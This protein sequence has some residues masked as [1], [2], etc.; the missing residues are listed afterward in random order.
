MIQEP[1]NERTIPTTAPEESAAAPGERW[2]ALRARLALIR[3]NRAIA[4][5]L[6]L[7]LFFLGLSLIAN[8]SGLLRADVQMTQRIQRLEAGGG[9]LVSVARLISDL[10][11]A[12]PL[13]LVSLPAV[14]WLLRTRHWKAAAL[15][16]LA[17]T[18]GH[19][20]NYLI[21]MLINR[22]R[23]TAEAVS[24]FMPGIGSSFPSG[25]A[26]TAVM[27]FGFLAVMAS[28]HIAHQHARHL[29][30]TI[31]ILMALAISFSRVYL[32]AHFLSDIVGGWTAGLF[33]VLLW[34]EAY[35]R[36]AGDE[37]APPK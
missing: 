16:C 6:V 8:S 33:F 5:L 9:P 10:G 3:E 22:P 36:F 12:L 2:R 37:L 15:L 32:G 25:H 31:F 14:V 35:K 4:I 19:P 11:S 24:V 23:P 13:A 20:L 27:V 21:K 18:L 34:I 28:I 17:F 1:A 26:M 30:V 7:F 29:W